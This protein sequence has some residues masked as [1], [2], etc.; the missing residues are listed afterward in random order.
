MWACAC[1]SV[2]CQLLC[3]VCCRAGARASLLFFVTTHI[4]CTKLANATYAAAHERRGASGARVRAATRCRA[5]RRPIAR[6]PARAPGAL[7]GG[8][9]NI[10]SLL[11]KEKGARSPRVVAPVPEVEGCRWQR[12]SV[13]RCVWACVCGGGSRHRVPGP[14]GRGGRR[15]ATMAPRVLLL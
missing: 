4:S 5:S 8:L 1:V 10:A 7:G 11:S 13:E 15:A 9:Q 2:R 6:P 14:N 12:V 3:A